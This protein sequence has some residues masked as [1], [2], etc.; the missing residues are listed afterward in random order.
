MGLFFKQI[1][2]L[3]HLTLSTCAA[4]ILY[5]NNRHLHT[6]GKNNNQN[7]VF[8][9]YCKTLLYSMTFVVYVHP[10]TLHHLL[11]SHTVDKCDILSKPGL[12][13]SIL[14]SPQGPLSCFL[15]P[16]PTFAASSC[17][18]KLYPG[19]QQSVGQ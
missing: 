11:F 2:S 8:C 16:N 13:I 5:N 6:N 10:E 18:N 9:Y 19:N 4:D 3:L 14:Q 17:Q 15:F 1:I 7:V 12:S